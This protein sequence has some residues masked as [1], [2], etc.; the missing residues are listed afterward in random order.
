MPRALLT[1]GVLI[2]GAERLLPEPEWLRVRCLFKSS[3][4][5]PSQTLLSQRGQGSASKEL[6]GPLFDLPPPPQAHPEI[7]QAGAQAM[8]DPCAVLCFGSPGASGSASALSPDGLLSHDPK[9]P[10]PL[11]GKSQPPAVSMQQERT[12]FQASSAQVGKL[13]P[14]TAM[15]QQRAE[16]QWDSSTP[17]LVQVQTPEQSCPPGSHSFV[18]LC[19]WPQIPQLCLLPAV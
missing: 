8:P 18:I 12:P 9:N 16:A 4:M 2:G 7:S 19:R 5:E 6:L 14:A 10:A 17:S 3:S 13:R 11:S 15:A 1:R